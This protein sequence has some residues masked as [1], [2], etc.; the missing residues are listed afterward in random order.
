M[1]WSAVES[2]KSLSSPGGSSPQRPED[3]LRLDTRA[4]SRSPGFA[5][6]V[7]HG[8]SASA[9]RR[10]AARSGTKIT[11]SLRFS[12][13]KPPLRGGWTPTTV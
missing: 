10:S 7:E 3:G 9:K 12:P 4:P 6:H 2:V 5:P 13:K 8:G 1:I 11:L